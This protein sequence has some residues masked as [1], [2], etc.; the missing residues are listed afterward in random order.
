MNVTAPP[1]PA[2]AV[3]AGGSAS[4]VR[5]RGW[6]EDQTRRYGSVTGCAE[7]NVLWLQRRRLIG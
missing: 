5:S 7:G 1:A 3:A 2:G 6:L 4:L